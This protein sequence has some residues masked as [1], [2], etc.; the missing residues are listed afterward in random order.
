MLAMVQNL[1]TVRLAI[2]MLTLAVKN[3]YVIQTIH[4]LTQ[5]HWVIASST[6]AF[7]HLYAP[8]VV[9]H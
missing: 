6:L 5:A 2:R 1:K 8:R 7:V 3:V 4:S 9:G